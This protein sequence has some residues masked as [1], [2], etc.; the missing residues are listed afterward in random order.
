MSVLA[1]FEKVTVTR[2]PSTRREATAIVATAGQGTAYEA[3]DFHASRATAM[4][5]EL[6]QYR[7]R[8]FATHGVF[9]NGYSGSSV[10]V[11]SIF[12]EQ[13]GAQNGFLRLHD[14]YGL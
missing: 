10:I 14:I 2:L 3:I 9:N 1:R 7:I 4:S 6:A 13:G 8:H 11:L 12:D 5:P